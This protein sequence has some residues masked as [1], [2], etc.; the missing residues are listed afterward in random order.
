MLSLVKLE[1]RADQFP[2]QLSGGEQQ[3]VALARALAMEPQV[4][5]LDE[6]LSA[7]DA[8]VRVQLRQE[9]RAIQSRLGI[10]T[11]YVTHDQEEA[12]SISDRVTIMSAGRIQQTG[13]PAEIYRSP[14]NL[15]VAEFVGTVNRLEGTVVDAGTVAVGPTGTTVRVPSHSWQAGD[16][17]TVLIRPESVRVGSVE[18]TGPPGDGLVGHIRTHMF[19]G[20]VTRVAIEAELGL[21]LADVPSEQALALPL[22][23]PVTLQIGTAGIRLMRPGDHP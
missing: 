3:R 8:K 18:E 21:L 1:Q 16:T 19:L 12:F 5:L 17:V 6:P 11:I 13:R 23:A 14:Q 20:A 2:H 15:F 7:L 10:T 22:D 9:I 4:L